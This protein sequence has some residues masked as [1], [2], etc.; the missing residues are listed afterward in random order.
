MKKEFSKHW[1]SSK[2][3]KKQRKYLANAK[4]H[5]KRKLLS[6][7]LSKDL[8]KKYNRRS[9]PIKKD[10]KVTILRG[11]F[12]KLKGRIVSV[13]LKNTKVHIDSAQLI[14]KDGSKVFY[15]IHPSNIM[16]TDL[17]LD[18]NKR[19]KSLM[20]TKDVTSEKNK[21]T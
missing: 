1:K 9:F 12:K 18:D 5:I 8:R 19:I 20:R 14:K 4:L 7:T 17:N 16:I 13:N 6:A 15:P 10:D 3:P 21:S 2:N 11:Q